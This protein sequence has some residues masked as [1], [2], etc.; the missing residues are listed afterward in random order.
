MWLDFDI[1]LIRDPGDAIAETVRGRDLVMGYDFDSDCIC[2]G[3]FYLRSRPEIHRWL[4]ELVRWLYD[5]PFEHDQRAISAFL[6]Y[7]ERISAEPDELPPV[8]NWHVF[9]V[10]NTFINWNSWEGH[11]DDLVLVHFVDG[12]AFSLYG[13]PSWDPSIP[14]AKV[15]QAKESDSEADKHA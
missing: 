9:D 8:P 11:Y 7:T 13:R 3:F 1:F 10:D 4:F 2:N 12:S 6:T 14:T 5:H 15:Q